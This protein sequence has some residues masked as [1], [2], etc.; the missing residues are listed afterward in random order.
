MRHGRRQRQR[1]FYRR[2]HAHSF[3]SKS[4]R[5]SGNT[6]HKQALDH[7]ITAYIFKSKSTRDSP[8]RVRSGLGVRDFQTLLGDFLDIYDKI[9]TKIRCVFQVEIFE[10]ENALSRHVKNPSKTSWIR[11]RSGWLITFNQLFLVYSH[12]SGKSFM[13]IQSVLLG[14]VAN[15]RTDRKTERQKVTMSTNKRRVITGRRDKLE[16]VAIAMH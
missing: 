6:T 16:N 4:G 12:I 5:H 1:V 3:F 8:R 11:I 2:A 13:K 7:A 10:W 14:E 15:T 9:A